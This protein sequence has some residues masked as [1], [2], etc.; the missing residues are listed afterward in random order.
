MKSSS[1]H[2]L[3]RMIVAVLFS[4]RVAL[5]VTSAGSVAAFMCAVTDHPRACTAIVAA[6][7]PWLM[8]FFKE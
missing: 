6:T 5:A 4:E 3:L 2:R 8:T 1:Q 7:L